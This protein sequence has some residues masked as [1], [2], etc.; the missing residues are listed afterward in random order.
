LVEAPAAGDLSVF[1]VFGPAAGVQAPDG[2]ALAKNGH[3]YVALAG[4]H[5]VAVLAPN[6]AEVARFSG[7]AQGPAG[8]LLPWANPANIAFNDGAGTI[9]VT[10]HASL[11]VPTDP[12]LFAIFDVKVND[13]GAPL[14]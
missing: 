12:S 1:H 8:G 7:P 14:P 9:L 13:K 5:Q 3:V 2:L 6:G 4:T 10:N 11:I